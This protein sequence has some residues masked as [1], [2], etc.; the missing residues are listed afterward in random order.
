MATRW[1][2][3]GRQPGGE[4]LLRSAGRR[5]RGALWGTNLRRTITALTLVLLALAAYFL[6]LRSSATRLLQLAIFLALFLVIIT[7][8]HI[9]VVALR[10]Y[11][12]FARGLRL[13]HL[14]RGLGVTLTKTIGL[15]TVVGFVALVVTQKKKPV[16]GH[17]TQLIFI[18]GFLVATLISAFQALAWKNVWTATFQLV[19]NIVLYIIFVN[20]FAET[21]WFLRY[22]WFFVLSL[23][24]SCVTGIGSIAVSGVIRA[25]GAM[26]NPNGLAMVAN[27]AA[28]MLLVLSLSVSEAKK[29]FLFLAGLGTC[30]VTIIFT[31][32]RG[33]LLTVV[34]TF[35]Y[36]LIKRRKK[37]V[38]YLLA[39]S[40]LV[41]ALILIPE[42]YKSRQQQWFGALF[43]G[44]TEEA[45]GGTRGYIYRS[46]LDIF[47]T[48][49]IIGVGPRT[50]GTIYR[51]EYAPEARGPAE[52]VKAVH[53]GVLEVLVSTGILG[54]AFFLG[55]IITTYRLFRENERLCRGAGL[56]E[57]LLLNGMYEALF[58]AT[59]V[60]GSFETI[61][62]GGQTFF[63]SIAA[64]AA[65][66][67]AAVLLSREAPS[68]AV[69]APLAAPETADGAAAAR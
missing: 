57:Y 54:F 66:N 45:L 27:F 22:T 28:A 41:I 14:F 39:A 5:V 29:R 4:G 48:S 63:V 37:L 6:V 23:I 51:A 42:Q 53:S 69:A 2:T 8:P 33:G 12:S 61:L 21:K 50:F 56:G 15:F 49:P 26:G 7:K 18:Y 30:L 65:V 58:I 52:H 36:Q 3:F 10:V 24:A 20:L 34:I 43:T 40:I 47:I 17:K 11:R 68:R 35:T 44:E 13:E 38:P 19:E 32:S 64:A 67:R 59:V 1:K 16:F 62:R 46:A 9:G 31:G 55:L 60:A 25:A